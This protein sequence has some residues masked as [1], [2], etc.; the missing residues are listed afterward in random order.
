MWESYSGLTPPI[1]GRDRRERSECI[2]LVR[3]FTIQLFKPD[4]F[5]VP[6]IPRQLIRASSDDERDCRHDQRTS[7]EAPDEVTS[8]GDLFHEDEDSYGR[9]PEQVHNPGDEQKGMS[10]QQQ[11][12]Q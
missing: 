12:T 4:P 1:T 8:R 6:D 2:G 7:R 3:Q 5:I 11:P 10:I 9:H